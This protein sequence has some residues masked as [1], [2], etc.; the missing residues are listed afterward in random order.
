M[1]FNELNFH[2]PEDIAFLPSDNPYV[3]LITVMLSASST[4]RMAIESASV[5]F[6]DSKEPKDI[7]NLE[8]AEI[9]RRIH[10]S[11]LSKTKAHNIK[12]VSLYIAENG[13]PGAMEELVKLPGIGE[14]TAS[15]YI[16]TILGQP[17]V[18]A[19]THFVRV[20]KRLGFTDTIDRAKAA[21]EIRA[22]VPKKYWTRLSMV[23]N[24]HGR[25]ICKARPECSKCFISSLCKSKDILQVLS[26]L[27]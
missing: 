12:Y 19:D 14:K 1:I 11:G 25:T 18:I 17:A 10:S 5:L 22:N 15:C 27:L 26:D 2:Y 24:L 16:S 13:I 23:L 9:E 21:R 7:G 8:E 3:F 20:A 4:D 6:K